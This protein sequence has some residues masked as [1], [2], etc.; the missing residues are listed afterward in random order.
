LVAL[1]AEQMR[2]RLPFWIGTSLL[3]LV[4]IVLAAMQLP[5]VECGE[6]SRDQAGEG[7]L[8]A[9]AIAA[10]ILAFC[11][12]VARVAA[13]SLAGNFG[14]RDAWILAAVVLGLA[15]AALLGSTVGVGLAIGG[16]VITGLAFL[17]LLG[18]A[19]LR[20][21]VDRVGILLPVYL[22][23][24]AYVYLAVGLIAVLAKS[25]IGC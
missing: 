14:R 21:G 8:V 10:A 16:V 23:G 20:V 5:E 12:G 1:G 15:L 2:D 7:V 22:F 11:A 18:A 4:A 19:L 6:G 3:L 17:A 24:V 13:L 9:V 25:G